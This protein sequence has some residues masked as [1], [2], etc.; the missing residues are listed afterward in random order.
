VNER[1]AAGAAD[2]GALIRSLA[3]AK[4]PSA[5]TVRPG[6]ITVRVDERQCLR[7]RLAS[8]HLGKSRQVILLNALEHYLTQVVPTFLHE[9]C[10]CIGDG[11]VEN[12]RCLQVKK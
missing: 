8:A 7:L 11:N 3:V 6:R 12:N 2:A 9:P 4:P 1:I 10:S 5:K